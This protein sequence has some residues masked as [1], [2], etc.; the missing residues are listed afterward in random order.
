MGGFILYMDAPKRSE[1][2][3]VDTKLAKVERGAAIAKAIAS[4]D[5][6]PSSWLIPRLNVP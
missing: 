6:C 3:V 4:C 2:D 5:G 1:L